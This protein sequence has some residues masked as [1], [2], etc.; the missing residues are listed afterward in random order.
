MFCQ[1]LPFWAI[2]GP[3]KA[4]IKNSKS[5]KLGFFDFLFTCL[6]YFKPASQAN[7]PSSQLARLQTRFPP[8]AS[9]KTP[10]NTWDH[11]YVYL[12]IPILVNVFFT[13]R[14]ETAPK[15]VLQSCSCVCVCV[16]VDLCVCMYVC[17]CVHI[18]LT[19]DISKSFHPFTSKFCM[20]FL[21][22]NAVMPIEL[23]L[24]GILFFFNLI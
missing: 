20:L 8:L 24:I 7:Q 12:F 3:F 10:N 1:I 4:K 17:V 16:C 14:A 11:S 15:G 5:P 21:S 19:Q 23:G 9:P 2:L 13:T 22:S 18:S 6:F